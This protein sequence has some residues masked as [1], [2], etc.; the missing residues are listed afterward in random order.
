MQAQA[1]LENFSAYL[2][3]R[4]YPWSAR[5]ACLPTMITFRTHPTPA[6]LSP[7]SKSF[8]PAISSPQEASCQ[9][10]DC[11]TCCSDFPCYKTCGIQPGHPRA[12][13]HTSCQGVTH[14]VPASWKQLTTFASQLNSDTHA[15]RPARHHHSVAATQASPAFQ[16]TKNLFKEDMAYAL[17]HAHPASPRIAAQPFSPSQASAHSMEFHRSPRASSSHQQPSAALSVSRASSVN[18]AHSMADSV[19]SYHGYAGVNYNAGAAPTFSFNSK[20]KLQCLVRF[21]FW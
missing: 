1:S 13:V 15:L 20:C 7:N 11:C 10:L 3:Y 18:S 14:T 21:R 17:E 5:A 9:K 12:A 19:S 6:A 8:H 16:T 2:A 4:S